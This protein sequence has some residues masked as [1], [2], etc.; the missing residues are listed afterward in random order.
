MEMMVGCEVL[1]MVDRECVV[2]GELVF[3]VWNVFVMDDC[4]IEVLLNVDFMVCCGE[5]VGI[6][7]VSGN[8]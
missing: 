3:W 8:G 1:F 6:V 5:V 7:G 4:G 2:F